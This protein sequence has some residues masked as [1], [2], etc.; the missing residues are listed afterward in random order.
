MKLYAAIDLHSDNMHGLRARR[1]RQGGLFQAP[2]PAGGGSLI[3]LGK[4]TVHWVADIDL[5]IPAQSHGP[6]NPRSA[7]A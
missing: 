4:E 6:H 5:G 3:A 7:T 2:A 1:A